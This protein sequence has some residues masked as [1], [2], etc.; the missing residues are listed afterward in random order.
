MRTQESRWTPAL[1]LGPAVFLLF[2]LMVYPS[3]DTIRLSFMDRLAENYVGLD[4]YEYALTS[5][6]MKEAF[7]NN[8]IWLFVFTIGTVI[9]GLLIA[10]LADRVR[11]E[12]FAKAIIFMPMA[13]SFVGAG[14]IWKFVYD[15]KPTGNPL[16]PN[17]QIGVLNAI[18]VS[19]DPDDTLGDAIAWLRDE[20]IPIQRDDVHGAIVDVETE[21]LLEA[22]AEGDLTQER[23]DELLDKLPDRA[24][25]YVQGDL[26][27][28]R[29]SGRRW[30]SGRASRLTPSTRRWPRCRRAVGAPSATPFLTRARWR[31]NR[32]RGTPSTMPST[33]GG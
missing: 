15:L 31:S 20:D 32:S 13:I 16:Q 8:L 23:A 19:V 10:T 24:R 14:V 28:A 7:R 33:K 22:V 4:N 27:H 21:A 29:R 6:R 18:L 12:S 30:A 9:L 26:P 3:L 5:T 25:K 1:F 11:Y 17:P 2:V